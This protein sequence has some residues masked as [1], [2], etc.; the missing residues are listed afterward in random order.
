[1]KLDVGIHSSTLSSKHDFYEH[2]RSE[3]QNLVQGVNK[4]VSVNSVLLNQFGLILVLKN[5][6]GAFSKTEIH[7]NLYSENHTLLSGVSK[8]LLV[9][10]TY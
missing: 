3:S 8:N 1:M 6:S 9:F 4:F 5:P 2:R 7:E 10:S